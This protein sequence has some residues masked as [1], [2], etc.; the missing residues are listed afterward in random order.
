MSIN[1]I[2]D[3]INELS[4]K[5]SKLVISFLNKKDLKSFSNK[6]KISNSVHSTFVDFMESQCSLIKNKNTRKIKRKVY[7]SDD[8]TLP[9]CEIT[10]LT[11]E[12]KHEVTVEEYTEIINYKDCYKNEDFLNGMR[13]RCEEQRK[14]KRNKIKIHLLNQ[15]LQ[16]M[17]NKESVD[18]LWMSPIHTSPTIYKNLSSLTSY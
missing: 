8:E 17:I 5:S 13:R 6:R 3:D 2:K 7:F 18:G 12:I 14:K 11:Y 15:K 16:N 10:S 1:I 9:T 4:R